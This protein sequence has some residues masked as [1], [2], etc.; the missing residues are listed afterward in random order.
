MAH[1]DSDVATW[2]NGDIVEFIVKCGLCGRDLTSV[3]AYVDLSGQG[4]AWEID[5]GRDYDHTEIRTARSFASAPDQH[6]RDAAAAGHNSRWTLVCPGRRCRFRRVLTAS[7]VETAMVRAWR[8]RSFV[9]VAGID[10]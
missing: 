5:L 10:L 8:K 4:A 6:E 2:E 3:S 9:L 1:A 7:A